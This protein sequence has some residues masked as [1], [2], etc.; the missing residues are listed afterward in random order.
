MAIA[1]IFS[2][3]WS[4]IHGISGSYRNLN[5]MRAEHRRKIQ[6]ATDKKVEFQQDEHF[7]TSNFIPWAGG[8]T[9]KI[10]L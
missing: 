9:N 7:E 10:I 4:Q 1:N 8:I 5:K 2:S 3:Y 6:Y